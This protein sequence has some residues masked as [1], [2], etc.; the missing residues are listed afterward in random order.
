MV[1][2]CSCSSK[3]KTE[4]GNATRKA[5]HTVS[6]DR[7]SHAS[8]QCCTCMTA[9]ASRTRSGY[10]LCG[11][12]N[13][14]HD[15]SNSPVIPCSGFT[16]AV[17]QIKNEDKSP[18]ENRIWSSHHATKSGRKQRLYFVAARRLSK[19]PWVPVWVHNNKLEHL[20]NEAGASD[21][22]SPGHKTGSLGSGRLFCGP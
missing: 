1:F 19:A 13:Q 6:I 16:D 8:H 20:A 7:L 10:A 5:R 22:F 14:S 2:A 18:Q 15:P 11:G 4:S 12:L 21:A 9:R 17:R 3:P